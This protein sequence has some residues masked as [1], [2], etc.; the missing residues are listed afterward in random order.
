MVLVCR[1]SPSARLTLL[2]AEILPPLRERAPQAVGRPNAGRDSL[3]WGCAL[4]SFAGCGAGCAALIL[5]PLIL[6]GGLFLWL[7]PPLWVD[8]DAPPGEVIERLFDWMAPALDIALPPACT[9]PHGQDALNR[10]ARRLSA[11]GGLEDT[12]EVRVI[13]T[14]QPLA[15]PLGRGRLVLTR[16]LIERLR[17]GDALAGVIAHTLGHAAQGDV[18]PLTSHHARDGD[19]DGAGWRIAAPSCTDEADALEA[20]AWALRALARADLRADGLRG[21]LDRLPRGMTGPWDTYLCLHPITDE[22]LRAL[23]MTTPDGGQA[24]LTAAQ[25]QDVGRMC[26]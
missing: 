4:G 18:L 22:R 17:D 8:E 15:F 23:R 1:A 19:G 2:D 16:G 13:D 26:D 12:P 10:L 21:H 25:W 24:A 20:D 11:A 14:A 9:A 3:P 6:L 7:G 5:V